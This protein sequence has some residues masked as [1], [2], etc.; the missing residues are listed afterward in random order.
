MEKTPQMRHKA[1][2]RAKLTLDEAPTPSPRNHWRAALSDHKTTVIPL[3]LVAVDNG[4]IPVVKWLNSFNDTFTLY[5]CQGDADHRP[6]IAFFCRW[7]YVLNIIKHEISVVN[8]KIERWDKHPNVIMRML[9]ID[10]P[11]TKN[12]AKFKKHLRSKR[13]SHKPAWHYP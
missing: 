10:F 2:R 3:R 8:G 5:S 4:I 7:K 13:K 1:K 9:V 6:M 12:L 11:S